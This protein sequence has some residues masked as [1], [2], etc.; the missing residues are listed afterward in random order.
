MSQTKYPHRALP[1][2]GYDVTGRD[3]WLS[4]TIKQLCHV[5]YKMSWQPKPFYC[6]WRTEAMDGYSNCTRS[7]YSHHI[8]WKYAN[9]CWVCL[10]SA[11][12]TRDCIQRF[13]FWMMMLNSSTFFLWPIWL[14]IVAYMV[15][16]MCWM[17]LWPIGYRLGLLTGNRL[18]DPGVRP[19]QNSCYRLI[20]IIIIKISPVRALTVDF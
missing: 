13:D 4:E 9:S 16:F 8:A 15:F 2:A 7:N 18:T 20:I 10:L 6:W 3:V 11:Y 12:L 1:T 19:V 14:L 5:N 17:W